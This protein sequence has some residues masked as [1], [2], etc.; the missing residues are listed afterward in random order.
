MYI[1][2]G[3]GQCV[4]DTA[5]ITVL[6]QAPPNA[7]ISA[8]LALCNNGSPV[9]L[10]SALGGSP[11]N[12]GQWTLSDGSLTDGTFNPTTDLANSFTYTVQAIAPC[13]AVNSTVIVTVADAPSAAWTSPSALCRSA[14]PIDLSNTVT[15]ESGGT[16]SGPGIAADGQHFDPAS[17]TPQ[18]NSEDY[19]LTY[20][21]VM[22]GCTNAQSGSITVMANPVANAG[23]DGEE[24]A[25]EHALTASQNIGSGTWSAANGITFNEPD[26]PNTMVHVPVSGTYAMRW[27]VTNGPCSAVDTV[28]SS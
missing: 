8:N 6:E 25:L 3:S 5:F 18:G 13:S 17:L 11:D 4:A 1:V 27:T 9:N 22:G 12:G 7:G 26:A 2:A 19:T 20:T 15:G 28:C 16:W 10:F 24:C 23:P 21:V 14:Q